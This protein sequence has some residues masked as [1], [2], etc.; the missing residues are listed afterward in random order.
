MM[1]GTLDARRID[2]GGINLNVIDAGDGPAVLLLHGFPDRAAMWSSQIH[3]LTEAGYRVIA[4]DLRGF[5]DSDR[6]RD[7][8]HYTI[9]LLVG[10]IIALLAALEVP[11]VAVV[12]HDWGASV[13]WTL[14]AVSPG[15]V[16]RLAAFSVGHPRAFFSAGDRQRQLSWYVLLFT[17]PGIEEQLPH[18]EWRWYRQWAFAGAQ[19]DQNPQLAAQLTDLARPGA[20]DAGLNYYRANFPAAAFL[21]DGG[22]ADAVPNVTCPVLGVWSDR[23]MALTEEQMTGSAEYVDAE[24]RYVRIPGVGHWIPTDAADTVNALLQDFLGEGSTTTTPTT[25]KKGLITP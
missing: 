6:P 13:A 21:L 7:V 12:G 4:P 11:E 1:P 18:Q 16:A 14:A 23:D 2:V 9:D 3:H 15:Q 10:D 24:F 19:P 25:T 5:G 20:L 22:P 8:T 17:S